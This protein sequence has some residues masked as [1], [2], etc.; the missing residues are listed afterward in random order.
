LIAQHSPDDEFREYALKMMAY[1]IKSGEID[2][3]DYALTF[4]RVQV[5][6]GLPQRYGSQARCSA[7]R[8]V[9][10]PLETEDAVN[11]ERERIGWAQTIEETKGDLEI[12]KPCTW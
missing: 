12:G 7:G 4:D 9:L 3:R 2:A 6:K 11:E 10:A 5:H 8:R 1:R